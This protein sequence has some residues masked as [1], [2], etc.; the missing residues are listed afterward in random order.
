MKGRKERKRLERLKEIQ[1]YKKA[2]KV[3]ALTALGSEVV[4]YIFSLLK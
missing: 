4:K 2:I 1:E 3:G